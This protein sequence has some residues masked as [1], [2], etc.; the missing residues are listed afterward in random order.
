MKLS[1]VKLRPKFVISPVVKQVPGV[2]RMTA[3]L[4]RQLKFHF[5]SNHTQNDLASLEGHSSG[6]NHTWQCSEKN[7]NSQTNFLSG[8]FHQSTASVIRSFCEVFVILFREIL[9]TVY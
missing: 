6:T 5:T 3:H 4:R 9:I 7:R 1:F 2:E 8:R